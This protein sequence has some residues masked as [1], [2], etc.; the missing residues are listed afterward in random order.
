[1]PGSPCLRLVVFAVFAWG[2]VRKVAEHRERCMAFFAVMLAGTRSY[3][4][5]PDSMY[6]GLL[7]F[8]RDNKL[9]CCN[10]LS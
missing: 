7:L 3:P 5:S 9:P 4:P 6:E 1:M 10:L 8:A 2:D